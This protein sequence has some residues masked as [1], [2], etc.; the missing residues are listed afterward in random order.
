M[1][2]APR[3]SRRI[4]VLVDRSGSTATTTGDRNSPATHRIKMSHFSFRGSPTN[5]QVSVKPPNC[6]E[7][8]YDHIAA[9]NKIG[10]VYCGC[11]NRVDRKCVFISFGEWNCSVQ[12]WRYRNPAWAA[13]VC[14][15]KT[16]KNKQFHSLNCTKIRVLRVFVTVAFTPVQVSY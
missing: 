7:K 5:I 2:L 15:V 1:V 16:P 9:N 6:R 8:G 11:A 4:E 13:P 3:R 10:S 14:C 12:R